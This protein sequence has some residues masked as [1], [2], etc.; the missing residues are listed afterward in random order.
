ME[1]GI[2][3]VHTQRV[4]VDDPDAGEVGERRPPD[5]AAA[6]ELFRELEFA[7]LTREFADAKVVPV[8]STSDLDY[9]VVRNR[10]ELDAF[11]RSEDKRMGDIVKA[12]NLDLK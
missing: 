7:N 4:V 2:R 11:R 12:A 10:A 9:K 6:Y 5:R 1:P 3:G 8:A